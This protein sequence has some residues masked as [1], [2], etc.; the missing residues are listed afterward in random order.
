MSQDEGQDFRIALAGTLPGEQ[1]NGWDDDTLKA[2]LYRNRAKVRY[3]RVAYN[4]ASSKEI[5]STGK[6][7]LTIQLVRIEPVGESLDSLEEAELMHFF[8]QRTGQATLLAPVE[9]STNDPT[10]GPWPGDP[11]WREPA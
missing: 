6:R 4:V 3:A 7:I 1:A 5:T 8:E 11:E 9:G 2:D 10:A